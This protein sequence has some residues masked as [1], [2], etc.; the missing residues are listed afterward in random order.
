MCVKLAKHKNFDAFLD[1]L[2]PLERSICLQM[3]NLIIGNFPELRETWAYGAPYYKGKSTICFLYPASL[4][5]SGLEYGVHWGFAKGYLLSNVQH[6]LVQGNRKQ[7][8][9]VSL[10][11]LQDIQPDLLLEI[12]H[13]AWLLDQM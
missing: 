5:Y 12:L 11:S 7:V 3:R 2:T 10:Q 1:A 9:Y 4:P 6:L 13:E 8:A